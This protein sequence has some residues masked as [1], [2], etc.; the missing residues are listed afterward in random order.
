M[1]V[2]RLGKVF[3]AIAGYALSGVEVLSNCLHAAL[4][5]FDPFIQAGGSDG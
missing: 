2:A 4:L 3:F 1:L 5:Q